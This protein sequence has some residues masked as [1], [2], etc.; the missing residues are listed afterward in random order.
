MRKSYLRLS[1]LIQKETAQLL[2]D[3]RT[4]V[5]I[6]GLPLIELFLFA[7]AVSLTVYHLPTAVADQS[8]DVQSRDLIRAFVNSQY[9]DVTLTAQ[10]EAQVRHALDAGEVKAGLI[11]PP[12]FSTRLENGDA[13]V[14]ILLDGSDSFSVQSGF[15]AANLISQN[16]GLEWAIQKTEKTGGKTMFVARAAS[17]PITNSFRVLYNPDFRDLWFVLPA[18]IGMILQTAAVAQAALIVVRERELGTIEQIL[19][20]PT[21]PLELLLGKM[22]PLLVLCYLVIG[23]ILIL[24]VFWFG[25]AFKGSLGLYLLLTLAFVM[26]SLGLG[27]LISTVAK[28][29]RQAQQIS[30]VLMLFS[31]LLTGIVYPRNVMP[32]IPQWIGS[33]LPLTYFIRISRGIIMKGVGLTFLWSDVLAL[34]IYSLVVMISAALNFRKRLD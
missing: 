33:M 15:S 3:V 25:V 11:I 16:Y 27:F 10:D 14:L 2:R 34:V 31:M 13:D 23:L 4:L 21:R 12:D 28:T 18:I 1:A 26:S 8:Q 30:T 22:I 7:Y 9:F 24:G 17:R 20:T 32:L 19:A 29:Q 5:F 6:V